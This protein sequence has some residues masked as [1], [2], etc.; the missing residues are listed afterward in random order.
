MV[1]EYCV[2]EFS[3]EELWVFNA[4]FLGAGCSK[5]FGYPLTSQLLPKALEGL[6]NKT[7]FTGIERLKPPAR[8]A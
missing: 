8:L 7:L 5:N 4:F 6:K 2:A 3:P 1:L